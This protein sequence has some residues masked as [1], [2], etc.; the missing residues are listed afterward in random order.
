MSSVLVQSKSTAGLE[1]KRTTHRVYVVRSKIDGIELH[2]CLGIDIM[3]TVICPITPPGLIERPLIADADEV[4]RVQTFD[5]YASFFCPFGHQGWG[6]VQ[7]SRKVPD[8]I[9]PTTRFV[10][11]FP[12]EHRRRVPVPRHHGFDVFLESGLDLWDPEG[13]RSFGWCEC[14]CTPQDEEYWDTYVIVVFSL[15]NRLRPF[16]PSSVWASE[17]IQRLEHK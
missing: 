12:A 13:L 7:H 14:S 5:I 4:P 2:K 6:T 1:R 11:G 15:S 17:R 10:S 3:S 16:S 9:H 8:T